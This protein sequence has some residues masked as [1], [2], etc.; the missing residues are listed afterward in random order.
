MWLC[1][2]FRYVVVGIEDD[3]V[4]VIV[5]L[6]VS[7]ANDIVATVTQGSVE[8][9]RL[10]PGRPVV[11]LVKAPCVSLAPPG[12]HFSRPAKTGCRDK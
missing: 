1:N 2:V 3:P 8:H 12:R 10:A 9:L 7:A 11:A 6:S 4:D 5:T